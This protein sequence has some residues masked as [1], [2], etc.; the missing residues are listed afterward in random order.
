MHRVYLL[1]HILSRNND[2]GITSISHVP[3]ITVEV[4]MYRAGYRALCKEVLMIGIS[5]FENNLI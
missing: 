2:I 5:T 1:D 4:G 3:Y